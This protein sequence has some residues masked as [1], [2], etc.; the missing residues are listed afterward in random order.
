MNKI[1]I[2]S[3]Q[4]LVGGKQLEETPQFKSALEER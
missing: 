1:K 4:V 3:S 2:L